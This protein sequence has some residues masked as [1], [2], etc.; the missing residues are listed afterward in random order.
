MT[1]HS[2]PSLTSLIEAAVRDAAGPCQ[3]EHTWC[4]W[5]E[6]YAPSAPM[7][8]AMNDYLEIATQVALVVVEG[9]LSGIDT[10]R[11][12]TKVPD[13][14]DFARGADHALATTAD[15]LR[16]IIDELSA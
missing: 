14:N 11:T 4:R 2:A 1:E 3:L 6:S 13:P 9:V 16:A 12:L 7:C 10:A 8:D 5:H 15:G